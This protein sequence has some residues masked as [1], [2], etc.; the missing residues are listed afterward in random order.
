MGFTE[1]VKAFD[2]ISRLDQWHTSL[3]VKIKRSCGD[4]DDDDLK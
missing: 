2:K 1:K 3:L 4:E